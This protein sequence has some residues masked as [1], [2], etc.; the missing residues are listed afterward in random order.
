MELFNKAQNFSQQRVSINDVKKEF[1]EFK[2]RKFELESLRQ[3]CFN[4][5]EGTFLMIVNPTKNFPC[6]SFRVIC[7]VEI[8]RCR[9]WHVGATRPSDPTC[10]ENQSRLSF[11]LKGIKMKEWVGI[12]KYRKQKHLEQVWNVIVQKRLS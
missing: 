5:L 10:Y 2:T 8:S 9:G 6:W 7:R 12:L 4:C 1:I 3:C 11:W